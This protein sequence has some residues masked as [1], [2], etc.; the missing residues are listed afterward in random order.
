MFST[1]SEASQLTA[2]CVP[3]GKVLSLTDIRLGERRFWPRS[4]VHNVRCEKRHLMH[5]PSRWLTW[6][7]LYSTVYKPPQGAM[8]MTYCIT[9]SAQ[10]QHPSPHSSHT[11]NLWKLITS[12][13][14]DYNH[15]EC[16]LPLLIY[17]G[18]LYR[19]YNVALG[20]PETYFFPFL[21]N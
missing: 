7:M 9:L 13:A 15:F 17:E 18:P 11:S 6:C 1:Q 12:N 19:L 2:H 10:L 8:V 16:N 14:Q 4:Q 21:V 20:Q 3:L 5:A